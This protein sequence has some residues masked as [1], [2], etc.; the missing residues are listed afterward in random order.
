MP[1]DKSIE[2]NEYYGHPRNRFWKILAWITNNKEPG[3]YA[4]KLSLLQLL[5]IGLWDVVHQATREGSLDSAIKDAIPND[6]DHFFDHHKSIEV[7][8]FNGQKAEKM[9]D[10]HF[11][12]KP[13]LRYVSLPSSSP[14]N[15]TYNFEKISMIWKEGL[16]I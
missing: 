2:L 11:Q 15:A 5:R 7:L 1:G 10:K 8:A 12:R 4:E 9:F 16:M 6:L 14:A 3:N 13:G